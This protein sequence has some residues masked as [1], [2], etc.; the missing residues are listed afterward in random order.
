MT[1][2]PRKPRL[3]AEQRRALEMLNRSPRSGC[4]ASLL[5]AHGFPLAVLV[6]LVDDGLVHAQTETVRGPP[7][8]R[9]EIVRVKI[10][11][12]GRKALK[13]PD[14]WGGS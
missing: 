1:M 12:A 7:D 2:L 5:D 3:T 8:R 9:I 4:I 11:A 14:D 13:G 10:T 6:G